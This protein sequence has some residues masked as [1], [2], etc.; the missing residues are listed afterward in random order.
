MVDVSLGNKDRDNN[1]M[2]KT[3]LTILGVVFLTIGVLGFFNDPL[4]GIFDVDSLHN[5]IH[6]LSG[7]LAFIAV[8]KGREQ[9]RTYSKV[10]GVTYGLVAILGFLVPG[11]MILGLFA[12]NM[13]DD[14]LHLVIATTFLYVGYG[15]ATHRSNPMD[16][17]L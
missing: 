12:S 9:M 16:S 8:S 6:I 10:F 11:D 5:V 3:I 17:A 4:L 1:R 7:V 14:V 15:R 2:D 13:A